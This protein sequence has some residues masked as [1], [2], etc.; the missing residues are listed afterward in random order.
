MLKHAEA[1]VS[2]RK[3]KEN[4]MLKVL[5][6]LA[7]LAASATA[8]ENFVLAEGNLATG[9]GISFG[10]RYIL[11]EAVDIDS[12]SGIRLFVN[13]GAAF[14]VESGVAAR[15]YCC[16]NF[17]V[18]PEVCGGMAYLGG[19][20]M[21]SAWMSYFSVGVRTETKLDERLSLVV[22]GTIIPLGNSSGVYPGLH[23]GLKVGF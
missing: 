19:D 18:G 3:Y 16:N 12:W 11:N 21:T 17:S 15:I 8:Y 6:L 5:T 10:S 14:S 13:H 7:S 23:I 20:G 4:N 9:G 22:R 1:Q 2:A